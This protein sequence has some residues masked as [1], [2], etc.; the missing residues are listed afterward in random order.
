[1]LGSMY[2]GTSGT[3]LAY[4]KNF[5]SAGRL[6]QVLSMAR[7]F[8]TGDWFDP[9]GFHVVTNLNML[10]ADFIELCAIRKLIPEQ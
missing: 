2:V 6:D 5:V 3:K 7:H 10:L 9:S 1:M 8:L 4:G